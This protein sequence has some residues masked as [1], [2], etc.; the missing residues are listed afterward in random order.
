MAKTVSI[1]MVGDKEVIGALDTSFLAPGSKI[2]PG[3]LGG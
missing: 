2:Y 3:T 1:M